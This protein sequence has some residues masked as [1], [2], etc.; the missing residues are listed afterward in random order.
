MNPDTYDW[1]RVGHIVGFV[2]WIGGLLTVLQ[3]LR[4]HG[5]VEGAARDVLARHERKMAVVM[6]AG[7]TLAIICGLWMALD[8]DPTYFSAKTYGPWLH[9][10]LTIVAVAIIG[11][12]VFVRTQVRKFRK[13]QVKP[14]SPVLTWVVLA[15]A[16]AIIM[17]GAHHGLLR[18]GG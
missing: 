4:V 11:T 17:L 12:Q 14:V 5:A 9:V 10:K 2:L 7:S 16:A 3:L 13:G 6:D 1:L 15:A 18:K 8:R